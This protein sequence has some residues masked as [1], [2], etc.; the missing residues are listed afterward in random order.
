MASIYL[1][2][3]RI[4]I[5]FTGANGKRVAKSLKLDNNRQGWAKARLKKKRYEALL[6]TDPIGL[7]AK[8][9]HNAKDSL[10]SVLKQ[11]LLSKLRKKSTEKHYKLSVAEFVNSVGDIAISKISH[12]VVIEFRDQQVAKY[13]KVNTHRVLSGLRAIF[14]WAVENNLIGTTPFKK[15][16]MFK[17][18]LPPPRVYTSLELTNVFR[19][20]YLKDRRLGDQLMFLLLTG[21][22]SAESCNLKWCDVDTD[23]GEIRHLNEKIDE[24][25]SFPVGEVTTAFL[26]EISHDFDP[27]VFA[28]RS[29]GTL[30]RRLKPITKGL[31]LHE[32]LYVHT[33]KKNYVKRII[34]AKLPEGL[35]HKLSHHASFQTTLDYYAFFATDPLRDAIDVAN[36]A[37]KML[38]SK[39]NP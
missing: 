31:G 11:F 17:L 32:K 13:G 24:W 2:N 20:A 26:K 25:E 7:T 33:L 16:V 37:T 36:V 30:S 3:G 15:G 6:E 27:Y 34:E 29:T 4:Y 35:T 10:N 39:K 23:N 18:S 14:N 21:F 22:R 19:E 9:R 5:S 38:Q 12:E 8:T 1:N 28:F